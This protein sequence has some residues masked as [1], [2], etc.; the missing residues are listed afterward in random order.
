MVFVSD[1]SPT[2]CPEAPPDEGVTRPTK[3]SEPRGGALQGSGLAQI[4]PSR[5]AHSAPT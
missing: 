5:G 2:A 4:T 1:G 3:R